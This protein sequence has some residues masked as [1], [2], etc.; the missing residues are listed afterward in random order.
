MSENNSKSLQIICQK[1]ERKYT[2]VKLE[3]TLKCR[4]R[5]LWSFRKIKK[6]LRKNFCRGGDKDQFKFK[7]L[8]VSRE[9][10]INRQNGKSFKYS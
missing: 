1:L 5:H 10:V 4:K 2:F 9:I 3:S 7:E 6:R 8:K